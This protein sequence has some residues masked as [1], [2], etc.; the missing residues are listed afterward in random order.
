MAWAHNAKNVFFTWIYHFF[1]TKLLRKRQKKA[2]LME[3]QLNGGTVADKVDWAKEN[4]EKPMG[5]S[6]VFNQDEL[7]D[8]I[9][10]TKGR[11][12]KGKCCKATSGTFCNTSA[13]ENSKNHFI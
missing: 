4:F 2:H 9:G 11:G 5:V 6:T 10:V 13:V 3:I 1:Q 7:I 8:I 12:V